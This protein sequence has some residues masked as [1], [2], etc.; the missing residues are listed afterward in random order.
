M[1]NR[2]LDEALSE[3]IETMRNAIDMAHLNFREVVRISVGGTPYI[4]RPLPGEADLVSL[5]GGQF[6][7]PT[8]CLASNMRVSSGGCYRVSPLLIWRLPRPVAFRSLEYVGT[9]DGKEVAE[10]L[11]DE[12]RRP[13]RLVE[14]LL[15]KF[16][17]RCLFPLYSWRKRHGK[18]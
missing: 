7:Q 4:L 12:V 9:V 15:R 11:V 8:A 5:M 2:E 18:K 1:K 10:S 16:Y 17:F 14:K 3:P 13:P 6:R